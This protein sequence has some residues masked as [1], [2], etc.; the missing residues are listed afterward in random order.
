M[1]QLH[2]CYRHS[3]A[4]PSGCYCSLRHL[5]AGYIYCYHYKAESRNL[6]CVSTNHDRVNVCNAP[7]IPSGYH[8][9]LHLLVQ[10]FRE[11]CDKIKVQQVEV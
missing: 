7:L 4:T 5:T 6:S 8:N 3:T 1:L 11:T 2:L 9:Y 10:A